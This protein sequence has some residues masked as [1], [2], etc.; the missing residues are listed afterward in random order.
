MLQRLQHKVVIIT[1]GAGAIGSEIVRLCLSQGAYVAF[2]DL[3]KAN[4]A[5]LL[6]TLL[7]EG[8]KENVVLGS[9]VDVADEKRVEGWLIEVRAKFG[10]RIDGVGNNAC[11][12]KLTMQLD[13]YLER[14]KK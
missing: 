3:E 5:A 14:L 11:S 7:N 6:Q 13:L 2:C 9:V 12:S 8:H 1:G 10:N 4:V